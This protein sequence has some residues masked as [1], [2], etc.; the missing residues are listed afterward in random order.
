M[1]TQLSKFDKGA[2]VP[3]TP[4]ETVMLLGVGGMGSVYEVRHR[5]LGRRFVLKVLHGQLSS[6]RDL[7]ARM[8]NEWRTLGALNHK[9]IVSV[10]DAGFTS[11]G[12]P[13]YVMERLDGETLADLMRRVGRVEPRAAALFTIDI[14]E[15][16]SAAHSIGAIH[17]DIKPQNVFV[18]AGMAKVLDFGVAKLRDKPSQVITA[19]GLTI[20]TPRYMSPEQAAGQE[21]DARTD[22]YAAGLVLFEMLTGK[23]PFSHVKEPHELVLAQMSEEPPRVDWIVPGLPAELADVVH[24]WLSKNPRTRPPSAALAAKEL[25]ALVK[26]LPAAADPTHITQGVQH[27][28]DTVGPG[29]VAAG[30]LL[31]VRDSAG[32]EPPEL[33]VAPTESA[34]R[35]PDVPRARVQSE[36]ALDQTDRALPAVTRGGRPLGSRRAPWLLGTFGVLSLALA[37]G[38]A[39]LVRWGDDEGVSPFS[40]ATSSI[41]PSRG[42]ASSSASSVVEPS[43]SAPLPPSSPLTPSTPLAGTPLRETEGAST[44]QGP[45]PA[46]ASPSVQPAAPPQAEPTALSAPGNP[47]APT[48]PKQKTQAVSATSERSAVAPSRATP[49]PAP[50]R[51]PA[52][53]RPSTT[54]ARPTREADP[55][56][57]APSQPK[58][59]GKALPDSGL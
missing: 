43:P 17:R 14:L 25:K 41:E 31:A 3:G 2:L 26:T 29:S 19:V 18:S 34:L 23:G 12:V 22:I 30:Q 6:R 9:N 15:G 56:A 48:L 42:P 33:A 21:V 57:P 49:S 5:V 53:V 45:L 55:F 52:P 40:P 32:L 28:A 16:L 7:V 39:V 4:Y 10:T 58:K 24:R 54:E 46:A 13:Y 11:D 36:R 47:S 51:V 1:D 20:G 59:P 37:V 38:S 8:A 44:A 50:V 27:E 35:P